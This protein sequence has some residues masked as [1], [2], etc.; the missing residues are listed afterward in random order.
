MKKLINA[1]G[2]VL[3]ESLDGFAHAHHDLVVLGEGRKFVRRR[4][5][6]A[7]KVGL[8]SGGGSGHEPMHA[9]FVGHGMLDAACPG[10]VFT[11]PTPDQMLAAIEVAEQGAGVLL[12]VKNYEGDVMNFDM[13]REMAAGDLA[14]VVVDDDVAVE[15]LHLLHRAARRGRDHGRREDRGG[16]GGAGPR[17]S[18]AAGARRPRGGRDALHGR[19]AHELHG[20]GGR[21]AHLRAGRGRNGVRRRHPRR[22]GAA[23]RHARERRRDRRRD[24]R[25]RSWA[26]S[27][28]TRGRSCCCWSTVS[29]RRRCWNFT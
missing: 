4:V 3:A 8:I 14:T 9:G 21:Q 6:K 7:G 22:A 27:A 25:G 2:H 1:P 10:N 5:M 11:A 18:G 13:A 28:P 12:I 19:G 24:G 26:T 29:G 17:P 20:A 15:T 16:R 23:A